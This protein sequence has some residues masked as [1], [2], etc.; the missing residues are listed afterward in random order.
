[1]ERGT[2]DRTNEM[3]ERLEQSKTLG[4]TLIE[5]LLASFIFVLAMSSVVTIFT[6][7]S[8]MQSKT[9]VIRGTTQSARYALETIS[10]E[11]N[12]AQSEYYTASDPKVSDPDTGNADLLGKLKM[13]AFRMGLTGNSDWGDVLFINTS[14][15]WKEYYLDSDTLYVISGTAVF[16]Y[17]A[18]NTEGLFSFT[19]SGSGQALTD[20]LEIKI[21]HDSGQDI[22]SG[23]SHKNDLTIQPYVTIKFQAI[24]QNASRVSEESVQTFQTTATPYSYPFGFM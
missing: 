5:V 1:M 15:G 12:A 18:G 24:A 13:P 21:D 2:P 3:I 19:P 9:Q 7:A 10:R 6:G 16:D 8:N 14:S 20:P 23:V 17:P 4:F 11:I 22:F